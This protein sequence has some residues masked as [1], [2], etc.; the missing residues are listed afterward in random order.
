MEHILNSIKK[1]N[2]LQADD[3]VGVACSGGSD[4]MALLHNLKSLEKELNI[5]VVAITVNHQIR[6]NGAS[7]V[8]FV[9]EYCQQN[10]IRC[11]SFKVD[12]PK[13]A[14]KKAIS[15]ESAAREARYG[16]FDA[17]LKKGIVNKVAIAH[18]ELDQAETVLMHLFR[19][20]G[21]SGVRGMSAVK[22]GKY[23]RPML[24]VSKKEVLEYLKTNNI[25]NIEDETNEESNFSRNYVRNEIIPLILKKWPNLISAINNFAKSASEDN[26]YINKNLNDDAVIYEDKVVKIPLSYFSYD[27]ALINR[28][29]FK[30]LNSIGINKD[31]ERKHIELIKDLAVNC[32]NGKRISL[33]LGV[34]ALKEY[35]YITLTNKKKEKVHFATDFSFKDIIVPN[36]G[37][38]ITKRVQNFAPQENTLFI[39]Y[40]KLPRDVI[41]RFRRD[42]DIFQPFGSGTKKLKSYLIDKK[43]PV[44]EREFL[45]VLASGNEVYVIAGIEISDKVK[46]DGDLKSIIKIQTIKN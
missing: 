16:V 39:D 30:C 45:P 17:L 42:G 40:K 37:K 46:L 38:I 13:L 41:W 14:M 1:N 19:G 15:L 43:I 26:D 9:E 20:A 2:L 6:E 29:I 34:S 8:K 31:I 10:N 12:A 27:N 23:I 44:R 25:P 21:I 35:E 33:P 32:D 5:Q 28:I 7:D 11:H 24:N 22:N 3:I 18:H 4:S 36:F